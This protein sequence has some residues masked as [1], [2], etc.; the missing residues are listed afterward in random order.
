VLSIYSEHDNLVHPPETS[1]ISGPEVGLL[2][3][4][5]RGHLAILFD[6]KVGDA[7]CEFLVPPRP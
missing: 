4:R 3:V 1:Q 6:R 2:E 7:V 5:N